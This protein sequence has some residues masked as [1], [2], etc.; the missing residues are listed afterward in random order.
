VC[1]YWRNTSGRPWN[2]SGVL[3]R[4]TGLQF[5][6]VPS[7][8]LEGY[9]MGSSPIFELEG[10]RQFLTQGSRALFGWPVLALAGCISRE[11]EDDV[12]EATPA[13]GQWEGLITDLEERLPALLAQAPTVPGGIDGAGR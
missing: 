10:R 9:D 2:G 11:V 12:R 5:G 1:P 8:P 6:R 4:S 3:N 7:W 13:P